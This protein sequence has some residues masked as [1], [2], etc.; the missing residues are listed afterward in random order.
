MNVHFHVIGPFIAINIVAAVNV[1]E[2]DCISFAFIQTRTL[3]NWLDSE[4]KD[5]RFP[6]Y[7]LCD[8]HKRTDDEP[9]TEAIAS[10]IQ[11]FH[12]ARH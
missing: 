8:V 1:E 3:Q 5:S 6:R 12:K 2:I 11:I 10:A 4:N 7:W 9:V